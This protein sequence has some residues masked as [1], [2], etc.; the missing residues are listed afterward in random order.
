MTALVPPEWLIRVAVAGVWL[1]EGLWC[2]LLGRERNQLAVVQSVPHWGPRFGVA[3]LKA[4]GVTEV[5]LGVWVLHG[6]MAT[7]CA[8]VQTLLLVTLNAN[9]IVWARRQIHDPGGM[10]V[11]NFAFLVLAWVAASAR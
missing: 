7:A 10:L 9:G 6:A 4:L 8:L 2:K 11:K 3:F 1:Y 5:A